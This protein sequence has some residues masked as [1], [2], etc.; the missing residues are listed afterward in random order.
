MNTDFI[1]S[2]TYSVLHTAIYYMVMILDLGYNV[3]FLSHLSQNVCKNDLVFADSIHIITVEVSVIPVSVNLM[4][5][6]ESYYMHVR[7]QMAFSGSHHAGFNH[8]HQ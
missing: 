5:H 2:H 8:R 4:I 3:V 7:I 6:I 1:P